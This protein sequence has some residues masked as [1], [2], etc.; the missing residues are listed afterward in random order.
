MSN[1]AW[2]ANKDLNVSIDGVQIDDGLPD[3]TM[4]FAIRSVMA[5]MAPGASPTFSA[6]NLGDTALS[7]YKEST[8]TAV[9]SDAASSG[10]DSPTG[11][12]ANYTRIGRMVWCS[13]RFL[14]IDTT[15]MTAGNDLYCTGL[16]FAVNAVSFGS[17]SVFASQLTFTGQLGIA[18]SGTTLRFTEMVSGSGVDYIIVS[19]VSSGATDLYFNFWY[20]I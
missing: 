2:N 10:N 6:V 20:M 16:P 7:D 12:T 11:G 1:S 13:V 15:G 5:A 9:L 4:P 8:F 18:L 19:E 17:A 14:N 3:L